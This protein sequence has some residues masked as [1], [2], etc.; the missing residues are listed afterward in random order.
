[1]IINGKTVQTMFFGGEKW[2]KGKWVGKEAKLVRSN[3]DYV[4]EPES[5]NYS[6]DGA[7]YTGYGTLDETLDFSDGIVKIIGYLPKSD[8]NQYGMNCYLVKGR[9]YYQIAGRLLSDSYNANAI[10]SENILQTIGGG[11]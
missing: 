9:F 2:I 3:E 10:V 11:S 1:M 6:N 4:F 5:V 8:N 7:N